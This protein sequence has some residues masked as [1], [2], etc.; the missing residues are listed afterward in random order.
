MAGRRLEKS[1]ATVV[2]ADDIASIV[3]HEFLKGLNE[4]R[5]RRLE[6]RKDLWQVLVMLTQ[7]R[8]ADSARK[9]LCKKRSTERTALAAGDAPTID[10]QFGL[11]SDQPT[12]EQVV[13]LEE[14]FDRRIRSLEDK[15]L[16]TIAL[17]KMSGFS[18]EEIS[19]QLDCSVR[20][21]ERKL[22]IIRRRWTD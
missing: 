5:F 3:F 12:P 9:A 7:R 6:N 18:N 19:Q 21:I 2:S 11:V 22:S 20:S 15:K 16:Q 17:A 10:E 14:E 8:S 1:V 4:G 13:L